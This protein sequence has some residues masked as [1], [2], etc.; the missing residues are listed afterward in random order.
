MY[1][2]PKGFVILYGARVSRAHGKHRGSS[3][4]KYVTAPDLGPLRPGPV[5]V[6]PRREALPSTLALNRCILRCDKGVLWD[7]TCRYYPG[8]NTRRERDN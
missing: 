8:M 5:S 1:I 7:H 4:G 3:W 6:V 2:P